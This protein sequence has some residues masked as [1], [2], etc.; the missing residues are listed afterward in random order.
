[1]GFPRGLRGGAACDGYHGIFT[2][3]LAVVLIAL[4]V[5]WATFAYDDFEDA[6]SQL[7]RVG[8]CADDPAVRVAVNRLEWGKCL[9]AVSIVASAALVVLAAWFS[10]CLSGANQRWTDADDSPFFMKL[11]R[12]CLMFV[13]LWSLVGAYTVA[14]LVPVATL[15]AAFSGTCSHVRLFNEMSSAS[16]NLWTGVATLMAGALVGIYWGL[17]GVA[18]YHKGYAPLPTAAET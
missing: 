11:I 3:L 12:V 17:Y 8:A 5:L 2:S 14:R 4:S 18:R 1:M 13:S 6:R 9:V 7:V 16:M 10:L 15:V